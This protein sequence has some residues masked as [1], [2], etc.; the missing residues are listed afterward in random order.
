MSF[1]DLMK[2]VN[3][4][5]PT[6]DMFDTVAEGLAKI[7]ETQKQKQDQNKPA[8]IRRFYDEVLRYAVKH[9]GSG[10]PKRDA[11]LFAR[12]LPFVRMIC[13][14]VAYAKERGHV[15]DNFFRFVREGISKVKTSNDLQMFKT[16]FE[17]VIAFSKK[18]Q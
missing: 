7:F 4:E 1:D 2:K 10:D 12:D 8:Q 15:D 18:S 9:Q 16:L 3:L 5:N 11:E 14:R 6:V 17:A 13:A